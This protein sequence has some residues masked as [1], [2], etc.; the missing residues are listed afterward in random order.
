MTIPLP[1]ARGPVSELVL[2]LLRGESPAL[3]PLPA[4]SGVD[5][6]TDGDTT[7]HFLATSGAF[8]DR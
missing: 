3:T 6:L 1:P 2:G 4:T 7:L 8:A 5:V